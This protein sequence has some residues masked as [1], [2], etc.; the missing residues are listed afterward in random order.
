MHPTGFE[1]VLF[2]RKWIM[3]PVPS[4]TQPR[5]QMEPVGFKPTSIKNLCQFLKVPSV[6]NDTVNDYTKQHQLESR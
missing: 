6:K 1:P 4:T 3:S 5:M 2:L